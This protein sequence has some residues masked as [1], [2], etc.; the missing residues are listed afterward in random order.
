[1]KTIRINCK[2]ADEIL[3]SDLEPFQDN[4]KI[5]T[6]KSRAKLKVQIVENGFIVP[7]FVWGKKIIDGHQRLKVLLELEEEGYT[8]P[9]LF[10]VVKIKAST[11]KEA[12]ER[13]L[14]ITSQY[15]EITEEGFFDFVNSAEITDPF[16]DFQFDALSF[17]D[18]P[19]EPV[20]YHEEEPTKEDTEEVPI[21]TK[22]ATVMCPHCS[23]EFAL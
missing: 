4:L 2:T 22:S 1:M 8:L 13:L 19:E 6:E 10:P 18:I 20:T 15:G 14:A 12:K 3:L 23:K 7:F 16:K 21:A 5:L 9:K 17:D 11:I